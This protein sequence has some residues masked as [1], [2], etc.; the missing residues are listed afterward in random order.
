[1]YPFCFVIQ[2]S[3]N[4]PIPKTNSRQGPVYGRTAREGI[5]HQVN[6]ASQ[7]IIQLVALSI[8]LD[9]L[10]TVSQLPVIYL[11]FKVVS[12]HS[13]MSKSWHYSIARRFR[14]LSFLPMWQN[15]L[16]SLVHSTS[17]VPYFHS[18]PMR[19]FI[20]NSARLSLALLFKHSHFFLSASLNPTSLFIQHI[21]HNYSF[22]HTP[23]CTEAQF[24]IAR[25]IRRSPPCV[26]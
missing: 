19:P 17:Q 24:S 5:L 2:S 8:K 9:P 26:V 7:T 1:M 3:G 18:Y 20:P 25:N 4:T 15:Q 13:L 12:R 10:Q 23:P 21:W 22:M 6:L 11:P 16:N 14:C